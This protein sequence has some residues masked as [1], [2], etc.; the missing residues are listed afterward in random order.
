MGNSEAGQTINIIEDRKLVN[1]LKY[2]TYYSFN[3]RKKLNSLF[4]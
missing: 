3:T 2:F 1:L 4:A